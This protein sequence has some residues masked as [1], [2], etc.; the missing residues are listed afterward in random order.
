ME[1]GVGQV[2]PHD[3]DAILGDS[4]AGGATLGVWCFDLV[5]Y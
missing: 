5:I 2:P 3:N 4:T 1:S